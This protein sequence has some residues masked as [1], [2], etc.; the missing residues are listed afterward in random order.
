MTKQKAPKAQADTLVWIEQS[1]RDFGV[2]GL[3]VRDLIE[4]LKAALKSTNAAVRTSATKA[5]VT[6]KLCVGSGQ[7]GIPCRLRAILIPLDRL[8][9]SSFLQDVNPALLTTIQAEFDKIS[10]ETAPAPTR[11]S[12]DNTSA[13]T[14]SSAG[15]S[16]AAKGS[17]ADDALDQL[18]PR[19][20]LEKL[21]SNATVNACNDANW[22]TRKEALESIQSTLEANKRLKPSNL[23]T[24]ILDTLF[25]FLIFCRQP[26]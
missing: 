26:I 8:D 4:F 20:D 15:G 24:L 18:F 9:I 22:K 25:S 16:G 17:D 13:A 19:V 10:G 14:S 1:L 21:L 7:F 23:C 11:F 3:S 5:I 6:L 2:S 12:A